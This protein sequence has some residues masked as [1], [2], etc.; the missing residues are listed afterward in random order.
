VIYLYHQ[1]EEDTE[2]MDWYMNPEIHEEDYEELMA[3]LAEEEEED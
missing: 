2:M 1:R 3:L